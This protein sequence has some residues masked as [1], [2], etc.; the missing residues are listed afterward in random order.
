MRTITD[1]LTP[2]YARLI[3]LLNR[4]RKAVS[5]KDKPWER[6]DER[7]YA[8]TRDILRILPRAAIIAHK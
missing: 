3:P 5:P 2:H 7:L 8:Q 4:L 1:E 6:E